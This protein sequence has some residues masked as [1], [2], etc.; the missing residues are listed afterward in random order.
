MVLL[1]THNFFEFYFQRDALN[2]RLPSNFGYIAGTAVCCF[3]AVAAVFYFKR[4]S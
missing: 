2:Y 3:V 1:N 4:G